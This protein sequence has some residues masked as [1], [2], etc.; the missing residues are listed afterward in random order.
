[1]LTTI[2]TLL[3][4]VMIIMN[5]QNQPYTIPFSHCLMTSS[6]P[7]PQ[8]RPLQPGIRGFCELHKTPERDRIPGKERI[9]THG[10]EK[11][12]APWPTPIYKLSRMSTVWQISPGQFGCLSGCA[13]S[14]LLHTCSLTE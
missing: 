9:Q 14:H 12:P 13:P 8:Q 3:V 2:I 4:I 7:V 11:I 1:M 10:R 5:M 6:Q